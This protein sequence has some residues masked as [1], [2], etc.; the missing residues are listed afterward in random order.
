MLERLL[1]SGVDR[2]R[3]AVVSVDWPEAAE[4][5]RRIL[6]LFSL[7]AQSVAARLKPACEAKASQQFCLRDI[8]ADHVLFEGDRVSGLID[9]G[10]MRIEC[11]SG[12]IARLL[13]GMA[14]DDP[15]L[16]REGLAAYE[17][18][19]P[20]SQPERELIPIFDET[21]VLLSGIHWLNWIYLDGRTF[22]D[23]RAVISRLDELLVRL[24][25]LARE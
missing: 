20:L 6:D 9:F 3:R 12:D 7:A 4:R 23:P 18:K 13:G 24:E 1:H 15:A 14:A 11:V 21:S 19:R 17:S 25:R 22:H 5:G 16:W 10:A 8:K 2:L